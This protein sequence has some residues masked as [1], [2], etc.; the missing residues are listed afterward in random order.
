MLILNGTLVMTG[1]PLKH[2]FGAR[3]TLDIETTN[4]TIL[5]GT[6]TQ[7]TSQVTLS[8]VTKEML[9]GSY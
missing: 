7:D 6:V 5:V 4:T 8:F 3:K 2:T 9:N 1:V